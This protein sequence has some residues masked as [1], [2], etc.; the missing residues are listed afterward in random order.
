MRRNIIR[1]T[2][3]LLIKGYYVPENVYNE[4]FPPSYKE[5]GRAPTKRDIEHLSRISTRVIP[6]KFKFTDVDPF[7]G[8]EQEVSYNVAKARKISRSSKKQPWYG[9]IDETPK[10]IRKTKTPLT[11]KPD[12]KYHS[13]LLELP[14]YE[15]DW[16]P[17]RF[18]VGKYS[19]KKK[20][21]DEEEPPH[22]NQDWVDAVNNF[23]PEE[24]IEEITYESYH[25]NDD[26]DDDNGYSEYVEDEDGFP[27][28]ADG[29]TLFN[30]LE[31]EVQNL[32]TFHSKAKSK[33]KR[34]ELEEYVR[35][36]ARKIYS[37]LI[38]Q[39][40]KDHIG[41]CKRLQ[42]N[43]LRVNK[44]F[45]TMVAMYRGDELTEGL[46]SELFSYIQPITSIDDAK[47]F[48]NGFDS[49]DGFTAGEDM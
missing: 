3:S 34:E 27:Y 36:N 24:P 32:M 22:V 2:K 45:D 4:F 40:D 6:E 13:K 18:G 41:L 39:S 26:D 14:T 1:R 30:M 44:I 20:K 35:D 31:D 16:G 7:T 11:V 48:D 15:P 33:R 17:E 9:G 49:F 21:K 46:I 5:L 37:S 12:K 47:S 38:E 10:P 19:K 43:A 28:V 8:K 25:P 23:K 42:D 29:D